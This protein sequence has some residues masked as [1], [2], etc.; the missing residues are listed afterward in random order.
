MSSLLSIASSIDSQVTQP[1]RIYVDF[2]YMSY[3]RLDDRELSRAGGTAADGQSFQHQYKYRSYA[4]YMTVPSQ[5]QPQQSHQQHQQPLYLPHHQSYQQQ[6]QP[7]EPL[8]RPHPQYYQ[9]QGQ[10]GSIQPQRPVNPPL[11]NR[12]LVPFTKR[13]KLPPIRSISELVKQIGYPN[14]TDPE[15]GGI[16]IWAS[17]TLRKR[18][19][20][21]LHRVEIID[22]SVPSLYP[23]KHFS[24][25]YIW[26]KMFL[27]DSMSD[28]VHGLTSDIM[29]DKGKGLLIVRSD[30]LDTAVAQAAL[31]SLYSAGKVSFYEIVNNDL[32]HRYYTAINK[33]K[34]RKVIYTLLNNL[35]KPFRR[36]W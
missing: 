10:Q 8:F 35:S 33:T 29:Y 36:S 23:V 34:Q 20:K 6:P 5:Q 21:F 12:H 17:N 25:I 15:Q 30:S 32:H 3:L 4:P 7:L 14:L 16:A 9:Q 11:R 19:Y 18:G 28:K 27:T 13:S 31:V 1:P 2:D 22:E 24:N 26:V